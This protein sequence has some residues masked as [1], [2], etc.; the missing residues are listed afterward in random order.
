MSFTSHCTNL[1]A[2]WAGAPQLLRQ[3]A[4]AVRGLASLPPSPCTRRTRGPSGV[5]RTSFFRTLSTGATTPPGSLRIRASNP[6]SAVRA[7][8][9]PRCILCWSGASSRAHKAACA[10]AR[11]PTWPRRRAWP[12]RARRF[13]RARARLGGEVE[14]HGRRLRFV[15]RQ[16]GLAD[17]LRRLVVVV[18]VADAVEAAV[19]DARRRGR[20]RLGLHRSGCRWRRRRPRGRLRRRRRRG[21]GHRRRRPRGGFRWRRR[22]RL[23]PRVLGLEA[24]DL[25]GRGG[26][27]AAGGRRRRPRARRPRGRRRRRRWRRGRAGAA[28]PPKSSSAASSEPGRGAGRGGPPRRPRG[29]RPRRLRRRPSSRKTCGREDRRRDGLGRRPRDRTLPVF[30]VVA[31]GRGAAGRPWRAGGASSPAKS[32]RRTGAS[33]R[34]ASTP[35][36]ASGIAP[37][38]G[39]RRFCRG[40]PARRPAKGRTPLSGLGAAA[41]GAALG[42]TGRRAPAVWTKRRL[43]GCRR[44]AVREGV[45]RGGGRRHGLL[46]AGCY[47]AARRRPELTLVGHGAALTPQCRSAFCRCKQRRLASAGGLTFKI[48]AVRPS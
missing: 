17:N 41:A 43:L 10:P 29:G 9:R 15:V 21:R 20:G 25:R 6:A 4:P 8:P 32:G 48:A 38:P 27:A 28:S 16:D 22:R 39:P 18:V 47:K 31:A 12:R 23:E 14:G 37:P 45:E 35:S 40:A 19:V 42:R 24:G 44:R 26:G 1:K 3:I 11:G 36:R 34:R 30:L 2:H 46:A 13:W 5:D 33:A 7:R